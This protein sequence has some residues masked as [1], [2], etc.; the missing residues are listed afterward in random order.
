MT[1]LGA[2]TD[3]RPVLDLIAIGLAPYQ[4]KV[5]VALVGTD[6]PLNTLAIA[7]RSGVPRTSIYKA[8][9]WLVEADLAYPV[10]HERGSSVW[11]ADGWDD[12]LHNLT[13]WA[14]RRHGE[15]LGRIDRLRGDVR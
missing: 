1:R 10:P 6:E 13:E 12:T 7:E 8:A 11:A 3:P 15:T 5:L 14:A 9:E 4:A 2:T